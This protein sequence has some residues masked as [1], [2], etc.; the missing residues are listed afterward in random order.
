MSRGRLNLNVRRAG[1]AVR[2]FFYFPLGGTSF[3]GALA[4]I[5]ILIAA[6]VSLD[7]ASAQTQ[8]PGILAPGNAIVTGFSGAPLP[9]LVAPGEDPG[10]QAFIDPKGPSARVFD[11]RVPGAPPQAQVIPAPNPFSVTAAQVGQVFGVALDSATPPNIYVAATSAYGLPIVVPG[12]GAPKRVHQGAPGATFMAALFGPAAQGGSFLSG[13]F[14]SAAQGGGPGSIWRIDGV[15]GAVSLFANVT[16]NGVANSGPALGGFAFDAASNSLFVADRQTGMIHRFNLSGT[17]IGRYDHGVQGLAAAG[18]PQVPYTPSKLDITSPQFS[19]DDPGTW[20]YAPAARR[21][22]GLAVH[23]GRLYYAVADGLEI[24]SVGIAANGSFGADAR[25]E[26]QVP[27]AE[28]PTEISKIAFDDQGDMLLAER[29][30]P[31]GDYELMVVAHPGIGGVLHY[32][33]QPGTP[34]AWQPV[35]EPICDRL[36]RPMTNANG[37]VAIG[38][39]YTASG[40]LDPTSCSGFVW[41]TGEDLR[42]AADP[43]LANQLAATGS[44]YLNGLQ[45][46]AID[47][48]VPENAPPLQSYFVDY[49]AKLD[50]PAA[51]G[52]MGDIAIPRICGQAAFPGIPG[53]ALSYP[54][55]PARVAHSA[56]VPILLPA[57]PNKFDRPVLPGVAADGQRPVQLSGRSAAGAERP[58]RVRSR[59]LAATGVHV[60]PARRDRGRRRSM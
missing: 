4:G 12:Q 3:A 25:I 50:D 22:F 59:H 33:P 23:A 44:L 58:V 10:D 15:T 48:L 41:S 21:I 20:D 46:N 9:D 19:S 11:L 37:G 16:L 53:I 55:L 5:A 56:A 36:P 60:L 51:R 24:W 40:Q 32:S 14:R 54:L 6:I 31:T 1:I 49:D 17:E 2:S 38:Y 47:L 28:G 42:N 29:A 45:G 13:L 30:S 34:G 26:V 18:Q 57:R 43:N 7:T 35:S 27:L 52:H 8:T 39:G